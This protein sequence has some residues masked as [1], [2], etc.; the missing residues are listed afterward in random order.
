MT[1]TTYYS[2]SSEILDI[3][4]VKKN[5]DGG[6]RQTNERWITPGSR[7]NDDASVEFT[8]LRSMQV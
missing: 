6:R 1:T 7:L 3:I 8:E 4:L 2:S 5:D